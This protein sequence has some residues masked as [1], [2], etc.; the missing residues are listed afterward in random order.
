MQN[1]V[2]TVAA[3][4]AGIVIVTA[5]PADHDAREV[6]MLTWLFLKYQQGRRNSERQRLAEGRGWQFTASDQALLDRWRGGPFSRR[7][8]RREIIGVVRGETRGVPFTAFDFRLR[9]RIVRTGGISRTDEYET[10]TVWALQLPAALPPVR[11]THSSNFGRKIQ[12]KLGGDAGVLTGDEDFDR[13]FGVHDAS[14]D[15]VRELLT[16]QLRGWLREHKLTGWRIDGRDLLFVRDVQLLRIKPG[17]LVAV[18]DELADMIGL[19]PAAIWT[20]YG[21]PQRHAR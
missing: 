3:R 11:V 10:V 21:E 20:R 15:F 16:P 4:R 17:T 19:F 9:T 8:D 5:I 7:G 18:A 2:K 14:P 13:R 1:T 6:H 12:A